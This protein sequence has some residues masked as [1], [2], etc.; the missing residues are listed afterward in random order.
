M[1][2]P[3]EGPTDLEL[4]VNLKTARALGMTVPEALMLRVNRVIE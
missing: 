3:I 1:E 2:L 4:V